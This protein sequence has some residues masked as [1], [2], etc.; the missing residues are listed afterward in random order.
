MT[1]LL[2]LALPL[3]VSL[4]LIKAADDNG[5]TF[6]LPVIL[7]PFNI[8]DSPVKPVTDPK[9]DAPTCLFYLEGLGITV[10]QVHFSKF[11]PIYIFIQF[12]GDKSKQPSAWGAVI[13]SVNQTHSFEWNDSF[14]DC[15]NLT[16]K[17]QA[18]GGKDFQPVLFS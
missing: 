10:F 1:K 18:S 16:G 14:A 9:S 4:L 13:E 3:F 6:K 2:L 7:P 15:K 8:K 11:L 5:K 17:P 12:Q